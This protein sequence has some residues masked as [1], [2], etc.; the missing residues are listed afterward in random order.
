MADTTTMA[1][2][3]DPPPPAEGPAEHPR[4]RWPLTVLVIVLLALLAGGVALGVRYSS[5]VRQAQAKLDDAVEL[6]AEAEDALVEIDAVVRS[7]ITSA[8]ETRAASALETRPDALEA[9]KEANALLTEA[10]PDLPDED[11]PLAEALLDGAEA[12]EQMLTEAEVIL[13]ANVKAS[14]A[15][16]PA[17][18]AWTAVG[19]AEQLS[20]D[21]VKEY[22]KH[23]EAG[24]KQ[25]TALTDQAIARLTAARSLLETATA[26]FPQA[27]MAAFVTYLDDR[28]ALLQTSKKID[29][30]WLAGKVEEANA[31]LDAYNKQEAALIEQAKQLPE[32]PTAVV[33]AAYETAAGEATENYYAARDAAEAADER[34]RTLTALSEQTD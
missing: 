5:R 3:P 13:E 25:S 20:Q 15:V 14:G 2:T 6:M 22:N 17:R 24:V 16:G 32:S 1:E 10:L 29:S 9:V 8:L 12:R 21:A 34:I 26:T 23:T 18:D 19:E 27:D 31:M 4:R 11:V 30:T 7:E 28:I 33:A